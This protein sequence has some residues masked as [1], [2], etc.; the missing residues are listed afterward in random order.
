VTFYTLFLTFVSLGL[1]NLFTILLKLGIHFAFI[2]LSLF[3]GLFI[4]SPKKVVHDFISLWKFGF[5]GLHFY[6]YLQSS[7]IILNPLFSFFKYRILECFSFHKKTWNLCANDCIEIMA[8]SIFG[9]KFKS[10]LTLGTSWGLI[11]LKNFLLKV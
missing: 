2:L 6:R 7:R 4:F 8:K 1:W 10:K 11:V 9:G 3:Y 5:L